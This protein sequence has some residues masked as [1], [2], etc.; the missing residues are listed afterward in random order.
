MPKRGK[1]TGKWKILHNYEL[2][3]PKSVRWVAY[4]A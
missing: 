1:V 3:A 2:Y 4:M